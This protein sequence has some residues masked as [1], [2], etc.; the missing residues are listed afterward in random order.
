MTKQETKTQ[1]AAEKEDCSTP[2]LLPPADKPMTRGE[3]IKE[4]DSVIGTPAPIIEATQLRS[5]IAIC[6]TDDDAPLPPELEAAVEDIKARTKNS[7]K[8]S[9]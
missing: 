6:G 1:A 7:G 9:A 4:L 5:V 8:K 2:P 3:A